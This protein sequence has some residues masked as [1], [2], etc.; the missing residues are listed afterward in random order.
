MDTDEPNKTPQPT[1]SSNDSGSALTDLV[2]TLQSVDMESPEASLNATSIADN[3][4]GRIELNED[5][6]DPNVI[7]K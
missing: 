6:T 1:D 7:K 2:D 5:S 4:G 3:N